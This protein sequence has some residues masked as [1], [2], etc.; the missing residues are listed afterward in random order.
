MLRLVRSTQHAR[1]RAR[2]KRPRGERLGAA[3]EFT[4]RP[5][6]SRGTGARSMTRKRVLRVR[7]R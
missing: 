6:H 7:Q 5:A 1:V 2:T 3:P 4:L